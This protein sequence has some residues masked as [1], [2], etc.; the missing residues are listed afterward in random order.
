MC[1]IV[2]V[3]V[4]GIIIYMHMY[5]PY[6]CKSITVPRFHMKYKVGLHFLKYHPQNFNCDENDNII[7]TIKG[8]PYETF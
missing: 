2:L 8:C 5:F 1:N 7:K 4:D 6:I 3:K